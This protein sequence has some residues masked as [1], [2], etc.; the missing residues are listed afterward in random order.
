MVSCTIPTRPTRAGWTASGACTNGSTARLAAATKP[1]CGGAATTNTTARDA[2]ATGGQLEVP[3]R[4][5]NWERGDRGLGS[6]AGRCHWRVR[7]FE[8]DEQREQLREQA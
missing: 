7:R 6:Q 4:C 5:I 3:A 1:A 2:R 8:R